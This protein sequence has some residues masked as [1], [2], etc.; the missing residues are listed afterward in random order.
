MASVVNDPNGRRRIQFVA[1]DGKR[2]TIRLGKCDRKSAESVCRHVEALLAAKI[3]GQPVPRDTAVWLSD[4]GEV[5]RDKLA[6]VGLVERGAPSATLADVAKQ[7]LDRADVKAGTKAVRRAWLNVLGEFFGDRP[8]AFVTS[9]DAGRLR[10]AL[11]HRGLAAPTVGRMLRFVRQLFDVAVQ[12][13]HLDRNPFDVLKHNFREGQLQPRVYQS[14]A[15]AE[16]LLA[17]CSPGWRTLV[18]LARYA[19]LRAPSE[20]VMLRWSDVDLPNR[21]MTV[22]SPK[23]ENQGKAWRVVPI[24]PRLAELLEEAWQLAP[25]GAE[26]VVDLPQY[27]NPDGWISVNI[28]TQLARLIRRAGLQPLARP[29][30][31]MRSSCVTDWACAGYPVHAVA[32]WAGHTV[33][34]AGRHYLTVTDADFERA[35]GAPLCAPRTQ[36]ELPDLDTVSEAAHKAAQQGRARAGIVVNTGARPGGKSCD[37]PDV[38]SLCISTQCTEVTR[39]GFEPGQ[40]EPKSAVLPLHYRVRLGHVSGQSAAAQ[41]PRPP[42]CPPGRPASA[43]G[44]RVARAGSPGPPSPPAPPAASATAPGRS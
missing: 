14:V 9:A 10:D 21:R 33:A 13:G 15:D 27:R 23:T 34:V 43:P 1:P 26:F 41:P 3:G 29:F 4:I 18:A 38:A 30:R 19:A 5:F 16:R 31:V 2:K 17:V 24:V 44:R 12:Q 22:N 37:L 35:T 40:A 36:F 39:P 32:S 20:A 11:I 8:L 7:Y 6:A 28:R 25:A 42:R